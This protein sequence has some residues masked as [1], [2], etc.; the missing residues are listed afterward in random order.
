MPVLERFFPRERLRVLARIRLRIHPNLSAANSVVCIRVI[1][2]GQPDCA[3][4][5]LELGF[6]LF[7]RWSFVIHRDAVTSP[8]LYWSL[9]R[10]GR[11][12]I[13]SLANLSNAFCRPVF[14][15]Y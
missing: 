8:A 4:A 5:V 9:A 14:P 11:P 1:E 2:D 10:L 3:Y 7:Y 13:Q 15:G 12:F 6:E